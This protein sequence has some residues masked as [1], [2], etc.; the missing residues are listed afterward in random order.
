MWSSVIRFAV[1]IV[2]LLAL[3]PI[4]PLNYNGP[5]VLSPIC[6][7]TKPVE[8]AGRAFHEWA[9]SKFAKPSIQSGKKVNK[10]GAKGG[11]SD[12]SDSEEVID[13][14]TEKKRF[15]EYEKK[16][17]APGEANRLKN[18]IDGE[19]LYK[20]LRIE[21]GASTDDIRTA[22]RKTVLLYHPDKAKSSDDPEVKGMNPDQ[23][24]A[25]FMSVQDAYEIL[26]DPATRRMYDSNL[27]FDETI[28]ESKADYV[29]CPDLFFLNYE[30]VFVRN[31]RFSTRRPVPSLGT[32]S[33]T[34]KE[35]DRFYS[36]WR[37]FQSW[38][39]FSIHDEYDVN[40][41]QC[42]DERRWMEKQ[43]KKTR[44]KY[45]T[46]E[47]ARIIKLV[48][49]AFEKDPR[50][51]KR[52]EAEKA[53]REAEK[54][55]K[56]A[57]LDAKRAMEQAL[58]DA[59]EKRKQ[60]ERIAE[61]KR[62]AELKA[63]K[64]ANKAR[65]KVI[66]GLLRKASKWPKN[67][68][69]NLGVFEEEIL[70]AWSADDL[71][72]LLGDVS[73][74][75]RIPP[76]MLDFPDKLED[77]GGTEEDKANVASCLSSAV[78]K[79]LAEKKRVAEERVRNLEEARKAL[80]AKR[81]AEQEAKKAA[82]EWSLEELSILAKGLVRFPAGIN[83]RWAMIADLLGSRTS[84]EV[85]A[86]ARE[87]S[88]ASKTRSEII[89]KT[90]EQA[91]QSF[92]NANPN[93]LKNVATAADIRGHVGSGDN[94]MAP[95]DVPVASSAPAPAP[96]ADEWSKEQQQALEK[97]LA[98]YPASMPTKERWSAIAAE[99]PD[100]SMK[101]CAARFKQIKEAIAAKNAK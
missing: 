42:R 68:D 61:E 66:R 41:A 29:S 56:Q 100:K 7:V 47:R 77:I 94:E 10:D 98:K 21:E 76:G 84:D 15:A 85:V 55:A 93:A 52:R 97:A 44:E 53:A 90:N 30:P 37:S 9:K 101:E 18:A 73:L 35:I 40:D 32:M 88:D 65:V 17:K 72:V 63:E 24:K 8:P 99:V 46:E 19:N 43:N 48:N 54:A 70:Q 1:I 60:E 12:D 91:F 34:D 89:A 96:A 81:V 80:E 16:R 27:P 59:E 69:V 23:L 26:T 36:F 74:A 33:S 6:I 51:I 71:A 11:S 86:K 50:M 13:K 67:E 87:L 49:Q 28:P 31:A 64:D 2:M 4:D 22:Y 92:K 75:G 62:L 39:D 57:A 95:V 14:A 82:K 5:E 78:D 79:A 58:K 25:K 83:R 45:D 20:I 38:R 3:P